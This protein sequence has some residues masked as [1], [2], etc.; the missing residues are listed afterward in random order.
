MQQPKGALFSSPPRQPFGPRWAHSK[1]QLSRPEPAVSTTGSALPPP[2]RSCTQEGYDSR[3]GSC[4]HFLDVSYVQY[5]HYLEFSQGRSYSLH[6][7]KD[8]AE[9]HKA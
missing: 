9:A 1:H 4:F 6:F 5:T 8:E 2:C 3:R 7:A